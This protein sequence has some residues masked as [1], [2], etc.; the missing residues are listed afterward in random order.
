MLSFKSLLMCFCLRFGNVSL[1]HWLPAYLFGVASVGQAARVLEWREIVLLEFEVD[2]R[3][4]K[5]SRQIH[6]D[7]G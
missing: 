5:E 1:W 7:V 3:V 2:A 4:N 6:D